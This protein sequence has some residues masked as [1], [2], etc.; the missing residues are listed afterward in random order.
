[1]D[2]VREPPALACLMRTDSLNRSNK[3][4]ADGFTFS[5]VLFA[6][7]GQGRL[8]KKQEKRE[9]KDRSQVWQFGHPT[10][11]FIEEIF[12]GVMLLVVASD[13]PHPSLQQLLGEILVHAPE[14]SVHEL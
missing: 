5:A 1:M 11:R 9:G 6:R 4:N 14:S 8:D 2:N 12:L 3:S 13:E 10:Q 7:P